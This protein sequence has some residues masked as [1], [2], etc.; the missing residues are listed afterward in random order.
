MT[1]EEA[2]RNLADMEANYRKAKWKALYGIVA[3]FVG[4]YFALSRAD[5]EQ[6]TI[7]IILGGAALFIIL[8]TLWLWRWK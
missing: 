1:P 8:F 3:G 4:L 6:T 2:E 5:L 7:F